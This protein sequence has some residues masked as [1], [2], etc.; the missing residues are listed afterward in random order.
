MPR[1]MTPATGE[2]VWIR[3]RRWR[4]EHVRLADRVGAVDVVAIDGTAFGRTFLTPFDRTQPEGRRERLRRVNWR[5]A[6]ARLLAMA[7]RA[8]GVRLPLAALDAA[9]DI[10]PFQLEASLAFIHGARRVLVADAVGLGKTIQAGLVVAEVVRRTIDPWVLVLVPGSL[11]DQWTA[12][13]SGRFHLD[14]ALADAEA[15][16]RIAADAPRGESPWRA[17]VWIASVDFLKQPHVFDGLPLRA[18]DLVV[19]DEAHDVAGLSDRH[20][21]CDALARRSRR[22]LL[23][24]ATPHNGDRAAF[25][26]LCR[27]G[28]WTAQTP[29]SDRLAILRRT[30]ASLGWTSARR[31][32]W[33]RVAPSASEAAALDAL[34]AFEGAVLGAAGG[35]RRDAA[36]LLLSVFRKRALSTMAALAASLRRRTAWLDGSAALEDDT[37]QQPRLEFGEMEG[38]ALAPD[39]DR[40]LAADVGLDRSRERAWLRRLTA[41][42]E[43]AAADDS[44]IRRLARLL[45]RAREPVVVFTEFRDSLTAVVRRIERMGPVAVLHGGQSTAERRSAL[46][47]YL[48][49]RAAVLLATDVAGQGLNLQMRGRWVVNFDLPWNPARLAQ[50]AGRVDRIGQTRPVHVTLLS[51]RHAA[52]SELL[53]RLSAR[54]LRAGNALDFEMDDARWPDE[55]SVGEA[56]IAGRSVEPGQAPVIAADVTWRRHARWAARSIVRRRRWAAEWR[57]RDEPTGRPM[58]TR[59]PG[60]RG[61]ATASAWMLVFA[62]PIVDAG[63]T[64]LDTHLGAC[65]VWTTGA[66]APASALGDLIGPRAAW[67]AER[68]AARLQR[69]LEQR[70]RH[71]ALRERALARE[72]DAVRLGRLPQPGLFDRTR[73]SSTNE[74]FASRLGDTQLPPDTSLGRA[75]LVAA[76]ALDQ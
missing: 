40:A 55:G 15:L 68:R 6:R 18:W 45:T 44:R 35:F 2:V 4:V 47:S 72:L 67:R 27:L 51:T 53:R 20:A 43:R 39:D 21:A 14:A 13:L 59:R 28:R 57:S 8:G 58:M 5:Q 61:G 22:V 3:K 63:G 33:H 25:D 38:D 37:W 66:D 50:R 54:V 1:E 31:V 30:P 36:V 74:A 42:A 56:V 32:R 9:V 10:L 60:G 76:I 34:R 26:R 24:T 48:D 23:L 64:P 49:G 62:T 12:E 52:E 17:G 7:A 46:A 71:A 41:L 11:C 73:Q 75:V 65:R 69:W 16:R 70:D 29:S 19:I